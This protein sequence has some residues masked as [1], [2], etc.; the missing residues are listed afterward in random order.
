MVGCQYVWLT[1]ARSSNQLVR[2][3][4]NT[5]RCLYTRDHFVYAPR[6]WE[7]TLQCNVVSHWLGACTEWSLYTPITR[8][9]EGDM[10]CIFLA[11]CMLYSLTWRMQYPVRLGRLAH[12]PSKCWEATCGREL[13]AEVFIWSSWQATLSR[14]PQGENS[15]QVQNSFNWNS[16]KERFRGEA[17][18]QRPLAY[19]LYEAAAHVK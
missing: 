18:I 2:S 3:H 11:Q 6:Q 15:F 9:W 16:T 7:T 12:V 1:G 19:P 10:W 17:L 14:Y 13:V 4:Y 5:V 8:P